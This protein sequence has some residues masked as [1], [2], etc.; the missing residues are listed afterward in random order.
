M[1][2]ELSKDYRNGFKDAVEI[3]KLMIDLIRE[4]Q[5]SESARRVRIGESSAVIREVVFEEMALYLSQQSV[6]RYTR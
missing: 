4:D 2:R 3:V 5:D 1:T 6:P